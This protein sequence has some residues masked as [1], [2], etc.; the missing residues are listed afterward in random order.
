M[1][2]FLKRHEILLGGIF[3]FEKLDGIFLVLDTH[4]QQF[5]LHDH[6]H[7]LFPALR[8]RSLVLARVQEPDEVH[9]ANVSPVISM[10]H[11]T[12]R[13]RIAVGVLV[14]HV[15][16]GNESTRSEKLVHLA[17][18]ATIPISAEYDG[19]GRQLQFLDVFLQIV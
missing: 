18:F 8:Q 13:I 10:A 19:H 16:R 11:P 12:M 9:A 17:P 6:E 2:E 7:G 15:V 3:T 1:L 14:R 4:F 5:R